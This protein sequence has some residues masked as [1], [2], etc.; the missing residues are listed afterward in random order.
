MKK[1]VKELYFGLLGYLVQEKLR[2]QKR[3]TLKL[4]NI[5]ALLFYLVEMI[6]EKFL[7]IKDMVLKTD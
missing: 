7:P 2:Y 4:K 6:L 3:F 5:M 1:I